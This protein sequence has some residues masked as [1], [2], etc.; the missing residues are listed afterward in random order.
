M[1]DIKVIKYSG[2]FKIEHDPSTDSVQMSS[3]KTATKEL[4]DLKLSKLIDGADA[5]DE[6]I[7]DGRYFREDEH[8]GSSSGLTDAG[9]PI[10]TDG[11]GLIDGSFINVSNL[12]SVIDH[13]NIQGLGDDDHV[14]YILVDGTRAFTGDQSMGSNK[15][16]NLADP[17]SGTDAVNLQ[18]L[19]AYQQGLKPKQAVRVATT[20]AGVL[21]SDFEAGDSIDGVTLVAGDRILIKD[22]ASASE[23]GIYIVQA[24]G[25]PVRAT[26]FDSLTPIDEING[27]Y[28]FAQEGASNQ[29]KGF[30]QSGSVSILETDAINFVF[31][32]SLVNLTGG[33]GIDIAGSLVSVDLLASGGLKFVT[34]QLAVEPDDFA[35]EGLIDDGSDNLAID[36]STTFND[37]KAVKASDLSSTANGL[38]ASIIGV[39]DA[40][41]YFSGTNQEAV[42]DELYALAVAG[43]GVSYLAGTGGVTIGQLVYVS[44][45]DTVLPYSDLTQDLNVVGI[46][47]ETA[48]AG[49]S[50]KVARLDKAL[51]GVLS[52]ATAG[53]EYYWDGSSFS[54]TPSDTASENVWLVG[55]AKN[56][57]DL[58]IEVRHLYKNS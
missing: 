24:T 3:F 5:S 12:E 19:Q 22:Q 53:D 37:S 54:T 26:D 42:N 7:H 14:Q 39:E 18:T 44:A 31:F 55:V 30:V 20:E 17:V 16:T 1:A 32:N 48:T 8:I 11:S 21:A 9:K 36:W 23:N 27:A 58:S 43:G 40:N 35:G 38:G 25:A 49:N 15:I 57:S 56:A 6:H 50:V 46:A 47:L 28:T 41:G 13:G 33:D 2:P 34:G 51:S 52:S 10:V 29:G 4:T 45:N